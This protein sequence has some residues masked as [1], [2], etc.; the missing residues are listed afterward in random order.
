M[1]RPDIPRYSHR[2]ASSSSMTGIGWL[3]F[4]IAALA[5]AAGALGVLG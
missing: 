5:V 2:K 4:L 3:L 1:G